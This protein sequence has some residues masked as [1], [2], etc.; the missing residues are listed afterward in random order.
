MRK[1]SEELMDMQKKY[2]RLE[3]SHNKLLVRKQYHKFK[4]GAVYYIISDIESNCIKFKPGFE[5]VDINVRLAQ[6]RST[7][8]GIKVELLIYSGVLECKLLESS[9]LQRYSSKRNYN[10]H[11]W[12]YDVEIGHIIESTVTLLD[13]LGIKYTRV[14]DLSSYNDKL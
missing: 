9:I 3:T 1:T 13:F 14:E 5:G 8:P 11:E 10:N 2:R 6:H 7:A 12:I 4:Q